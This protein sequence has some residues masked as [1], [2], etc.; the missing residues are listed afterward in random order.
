LAGLFFAVIG[1]FAL[2][3][4]GITSGIFM[5]G[6]GFLFIIAAIFYWLNQRRS[7]IRV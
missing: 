6:I 3:G 5:L 7:G 4:G 2:I 1:I